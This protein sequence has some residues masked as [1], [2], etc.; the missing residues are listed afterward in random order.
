MTKPATRDSDRV[1]W[2]PADLG[3]FIGQV[4]NDRFFALWMLA[5]TTG[6]P[7]DRIVSLERGDVDLEERRFKPAGITPAAS[8][9]RG[10]PSYRLEP[11]TYAALREHVASW[12]KERHVL[13]PDT[14]RLFAWSNGEPLDSG[15][16]MRMFEQH[17]GNAGLP[18]V[19]I[20]DV[21]LAYVLAALES[22][23]PTRT[24]RDRLARGPQITPS[25]ATG[26]SPNHTPSG[27]ASVSVGRSDQRA[28][29]TRGAH[30]Q[31]TRATRGRRLS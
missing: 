10:V 15:S 21:R 27:R 25:A 6:A 31:T 1:V 28:Q 4:R 18:V 3:A 23:I 14:T 20:N 8:R 17:C 24:F 29:Q 5:A 30:R 9:P 11:D 12:D 26:P 22:G 7:F 2:E 19:T 16:A 13:A